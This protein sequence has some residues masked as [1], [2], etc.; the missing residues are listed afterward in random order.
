MR[1]AIAVILNLKRLRYFLVVADALHFG[2]A[3][4][5]LGISQP[6]L[7]QQIKLL[8]SEIGVRLFQRTKRRV[9]LTAA[10]SL[11][12]DEVAGLLEH[13]ERVRRVVLRAK[14]GE[15]GEVSIGCVPSS[16]YEVMP[17]LIA[18]CRAEWPLLDIV[19][20]E[21]HTSDIIDAVSDGRLDLGLV[22]EDKVAPPLTL[23]AIDR[24]P[25]I[26]ALPRRHPLA[27][28][29]AIT[30]KELEGERLIMFPRQITPKHYDRV[31]AAFHGAGVSPL[32]A[33]EANSV[34][35]QVG[36]VDSGL[37]VAILPAYVRKFALKDVKYLPL[38]DPI[39][40]VAMSVVWNAKRLT[41]QASCFLRTVDGFLSAREAA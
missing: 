7:S 18:S 5:Q 12:R 21:G 3:A 34:P 10:G 24:P 22:W 4:N 20:K 11:L 19:V 38:I 28:R 2:R 16:L 39:E 23:K 31:I 33:F 25:S 29:R 13:A 8:E 6:P 14:S 27:K 1:D 37:G 17:R 26:V 30:L 41:A 9:S 35:S 36:F 40:P 15:S 32:V